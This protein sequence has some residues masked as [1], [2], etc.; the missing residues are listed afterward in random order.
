MHCP[1]L[2]PCTHVFSVPL[3]L[4]YLCLDSHSFSLF[5]FP[6]PLTFQHVPN[7]SITPQS[8]TVPSISDRVCSVFL[9]P[10]A[11]HPQRG[12]GEKHNMQCNDP[13]SKVVLYK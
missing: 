11:T 7:S 10:D 3:L 9:D 13:S 1:S 4:T 8:T 5:T 12:T 2:S 6:Y